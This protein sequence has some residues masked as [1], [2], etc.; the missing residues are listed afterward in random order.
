MTVG[1]MLKWTQRFNQIIGAAQCL[2]NNRLESLRNDL[3]LAYPGLVN[4]YAAQMHSAVLEE[5]EVA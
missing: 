4:D 5:L 2:K 1:E 3:E